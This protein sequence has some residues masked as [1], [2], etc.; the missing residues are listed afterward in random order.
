MGAIRVKVA[1]LLRRGEAVLLFELADPAGGAPFW[2]APGGAVEFGERLEDALRRELRE[3]LGVAI[4]AARC[5]GVFEN[6]YAWADGPEH[7]IYFAY[8]VESAE[9]HEVDRDD[10]C[11][12]ESDGRRFA[13]RFVSVAEIASGAV[14]V[15]PPRLAALLA[16]Q[17]SAT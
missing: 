13:A 5:V 10:L 4:A 11:V 6:H 3:E 8:E 16:A 1:G 2:T 15:L 9:P 12:V 7:E 14:R 17:G